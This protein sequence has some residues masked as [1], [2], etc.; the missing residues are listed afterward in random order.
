MDDPRYL[1]P[2]VILFRDYLL[3]EAQNLPGNLLYQE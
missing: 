1:S 2:A 3:Q